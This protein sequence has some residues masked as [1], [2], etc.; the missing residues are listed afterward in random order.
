MVEPPTVSPQT[1]TV[2]KVA[3][4]QEAARASSFARRLRRSHFHTS[5][6]APDRKSAVR[7]GRKCVR[8]SN[9]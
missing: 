1:V 3:S 8:S 6:T 4:I 9:C 2:S 5:R 7:Y